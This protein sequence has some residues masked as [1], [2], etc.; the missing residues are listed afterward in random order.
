MLRHALFIAIGGSAGALSRYGLSKL[1]H[2]SLNTSFPVGT[3]IINLTGSFLIGFF[4]ELFEQTVIDP[5]LR[6]LI[7]IGFLGAFTTFSTYSIETIN[8]LRDG[9]MK[10]AAANIL[11]SNIAGIALAVLGIYLCRVVLKFAR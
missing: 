4:F 8:L 11:I 3:L 9:E 2:I 6:G 1:I 7:T 5:S 10:Q